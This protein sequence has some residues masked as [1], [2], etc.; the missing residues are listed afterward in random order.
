MT[1]KD[2]DNITAVLTQPDPWDKND[3]EKIDLINAG[4]VSYG[5]LRLRS[6]DA[7]RPFALVS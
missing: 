7:T 1:S 5:V 6:Q 4:N 3:I 2:E